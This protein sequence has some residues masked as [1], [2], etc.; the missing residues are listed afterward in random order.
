MELSYLRYELTDGYIHNWLVAG[1]QRIPVSGSDCDDACAW[2]EPDAAAS[3]ATDSGVTEMPAEWPRFARHRVMIGDYEGTWVYLRTQE[4]HFVDLSEVVPTRQLLRAWAYT[5]VELPAAQDVTLSL[6]AYGPAD[7]WVNDVHVVHHEAIHPG[8]ETASFDIPFSAGRN[9]ILIRFESEALGACTYAVALHVASADP[10]TGAV[11]PKGAA[12]L[13]PT[14]IAPVKRRR[15]LERTFE[16]ANLSQ[17]VF[18]RLDHINLDFDPVIGRWA[19]GFA[20]DLQTLEGQT[21]AET[22]VGDRPS[23]PDEAT[24]GPAFSYPERFYQAVLLPTKEEYVYGQMWATRTLPLWALNNNRYSDTAY[25]ELVER[26]SE[27]LKQAA[28]YPDDVFAEMAKMA[29]RWWSV[30]EQPVLLRTVERVKAR[31]VGSV[32]MLLG[33]LGIVTRFAAAPEF[34]AALKTPLEDAIL[35]YE[36]AGLAE[37]R[38]SDSARAA[39]ADELLLSTCAILAGQRFAEH[40]FPGSDKP[41]TWV[42]ELGERGAMAWLRRRASGGLAAWDSGHVYAEVI[43]AL[44]HLVEFAE[45]QELFEMATALLDKMLFGIALN[46]IQGVFGSTRGVAEVPDLLHGMLEPTSGISR[47]MWG[48]GAFN[49]RTMGYVSL[50]CAETYGFPLLIQDIAGVLPD[51]LWSRERH[52]PVRMVDQAE[53]QADAVDKVMYRTPD[54]M[55]SSA[56][57]HQPG[58]PG[59]N[60]HVWQATLGR[61][62][63]VF[64]NHPVCSSLGEAWVPNYWRGNGVLPRVAQWKDVLV[65]VYALPEDDWMGFTHAYFPTYAFDAYTLRGGWAFAQK[66]EGY[67]ALT[68]AQGV[69]LLETGMHAGH[70]LRSYGHQNVWLCHMGRAA[71]D[72]TFLEFQEA[73]LGHAPTFEELAVRIATLRG[74]ELAFGWEGALMLNGAEEPISGFSHYDSSYGFATWPAEDMI[75]KVGERALRLRLA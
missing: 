25:G 7:L 47:L 32:R 59:T 51:E 1:P 22:E 50:A 53:A 57:D 68:A 73:I 24:L 11:P 45:S 58:K 64:T 66:G 20:I 30:L 48:M 61:A 42:R 27:A 52:A 41:G 33:L 43:A 28:R 44:I 37:E 8:A 60:E 35:G 21:Y 72:G 46:S 6:T 16:A 36:Y 55:L 9:A 15:E 49:S 56:Q 17:T 29:L 13:I 5:Q 23:K 63:I 74:D 62:A 65:A 70:E 10:R 31:E 40:V 71:Q 2:G 39:E 4:D 3:T 12:V 38:C 18:E 26:R 54:Y 19:R 75:I 14:T 34:P 69:A 67:L